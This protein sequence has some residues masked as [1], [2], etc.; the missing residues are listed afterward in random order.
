MFQCDSLMYRYV[1]IGF[2]DVML[3]GKSLLESANIFSPN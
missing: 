3:K 1:C 2:I